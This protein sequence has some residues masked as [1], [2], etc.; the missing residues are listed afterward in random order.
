[1]FSSIS[2]SFLF[3]TAL[4]DVMITCRFFLYAIIFSYNIFVLFVVMIFL[5]AVLRFLLLFFF[6]LTLCKCLRSYLFI[7]HLNNINI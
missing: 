6:F 3:F 1:M 4:S 5:A 7:Y 2:S